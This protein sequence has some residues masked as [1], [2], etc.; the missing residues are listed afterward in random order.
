MLCLLAKEL[1]IGTV[2]YNDIY[3][4]SVYDAKMIAKSIGNEADYYVQGDVDDTLKFLRKNNLNCQAVAS[5]DVIEHIYNIESFFAKL[6][7]FSVGPL[8]VVM[9]S[10]ANT[11]NPRARRRLTKAHFKAEHQ[12]RVKKYGYKKRDCFKAYLG[13]R[14][15][16]IEQYLNRRQ[17]KL[18]RSKIGHLARNTRGMIESDI[19]KSVNQYLV[20]GELSKPN[21]PTNT[22]DP[23]TGNWAERLLDPHYLAG[24]LSDNG[25]KVK[26]LSGYYGRL[27]NRNI[28]ERL[29]ARLLNMAIYLFPKQGISIAPFYTIYGRRN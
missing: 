28:A 1:G 6:G 11:L 18:S 19:I 14:K 26:I 7:L 4:I 12:D 9:A 24:L 15:K 29:L 13:V 20:S 23:Y 17:K 27:R 10:G 5:Y 22:C 2:I 16:M 3:D 8:A 21:H 25:F